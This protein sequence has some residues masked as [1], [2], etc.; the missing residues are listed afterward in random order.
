MI[1][2]GYGNTHSISQRL[3]EGNWCLLEGQLQV[4]QANVICNFIEVFSSLEGKESR[5]R[6]ST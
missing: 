6:K 5:H 4:F 1:F 2:D 3:S